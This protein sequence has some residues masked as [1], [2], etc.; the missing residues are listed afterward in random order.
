MR[1]G[2]VGA[3]VVGITTA[4]ELALDGHEVT[5]FDRRHTAAEEASFANGSLVVPGWSAGLIG[6]PRT[7]Q[8]LL[9]GPGSPLRLGG[10]PRTAQWRWLWQWH[11]G[12]RPGVHLALQRQMLALM[13]YSQERQGDLDAML[14]LDHDRCQGL[15][16]LWR[17]G[18]DLGRAQATLEL[19]R[20]MGLNT[21]L[22]SPEEARQREPALRA[23]TPLHGA[24]ELEGEAAANCRTF[25]LLL[26]SEAQRLGCRFRFASS[27]DRLSSTNGP[28]PSVTV[29]HE[30]TEGTAA[31]A[32]DAVVVCAGVASS[33]L[34]R[35][36]GLQLPLQAVYGH[37]ISAPVREPMDAPVAAVVDAQRH[38]SIVRLG[39][40]VR[41]AG[42]ARLGKPPSERSAQALQ[43]LYRVLADW[44][45]GAAQLGGQRGQVQEWH[46]VQATLPDGPPLIG[47][48]R[49][50][51]I[52]L[53]LGHGAHG[54]SMA[55]GSAR[56]LADSMAG[57]S[58][59]L[60]LSGC[61]PARFGL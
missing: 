37:S 61:A 4:Y 26:R 21:R 33:G 10:V 2:V 17:T 39:Q 27:V 50:R 43:Q 58:P 7:W 48:T 14:K 20:E 32:F 54:W 9:G 42:N 52:W 22:L 23:D 57:R 36:L 1:I 56:A 44:F 19:M 49:V 51:G 55:C 6:A 53:N 29:H 28:G 46:G 25:A 8:A 15:L 31:S 13:A 38:V 45:P 24:T 60:D 41:V 30:P 16:L 18:Q 47:A 40:R 35:P 59:D 11:V 3:G 5:V 34:L 12:G